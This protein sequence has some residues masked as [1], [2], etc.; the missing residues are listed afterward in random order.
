MCFLFLLPYFPAFATLH[1]YYLQC[2]TIKHKYISEKNTTI[3]HILTLLQLLR[4][5]F[6]NDA[7][8]AIIYILF[9]LLALS[10]TQQKTL[11][12][13]HT[14]FTTNLS[15]ATALTRA[16]LQSMRVTLK[17][18]FH[19]SVSFSAFPVLIFFFLVLRGLGSGRELASSCQIK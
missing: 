6:L 4:S 19:L 5:Y 15:T 12:K 16:S 9:L 7:I 10:L 1:S 17:C 13:T 2:H 14:L 3:I 18:F 11:N 8:H